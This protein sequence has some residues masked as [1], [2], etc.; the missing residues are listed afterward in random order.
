MMKQHQTIKYINAYHIFYAADVSYLHL[1]L[2]KTFVVAKFPKKLIYGLEAMPYANIAVN[3][4][5]QL[6][7]N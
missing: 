7:G 2:L 3:Y 6:P 5:F 1:F 4:F